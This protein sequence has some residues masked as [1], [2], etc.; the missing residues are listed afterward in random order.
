[1]LS[2]LFKNYFRHPVRR[3]TGLLLL[4]IKGAYGDPLAELW[5]RQGSAGYGVKRPKAMS[6]D[7]LQT[8]VKSKVRPLYACIPSKR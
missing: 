5:F 3:K 6:S 8:H 4:R 1:M 7:M 2:Y